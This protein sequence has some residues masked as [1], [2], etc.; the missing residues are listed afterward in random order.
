M[1]ATKKRISIVDVNQILKKIKNTECFTIKCFL[2]G[3]HFAEICQ[4]AFVA[5]KTLVHNEILEITFVTLILKISLFL[6]SICLMETT[7]QHCAHT[8]H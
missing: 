3:Y 8:V 6:Q 4:H 5:N 7:L 1:V 2:T